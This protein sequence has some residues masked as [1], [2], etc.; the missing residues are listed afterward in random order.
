MTAD[1]YPHPKVDRSVT[2]KRQV[3][4]QVIA[5]WVQPQSS[6]LDLGCGRGVLLEY[7]KVSKDVYGVGVDLSLDKASSCVKRGIPVFQGDIDTVLS[8]F[9]PKSFD[10]VIF[11]RTV[12][13]L[14]RPKETLLRALKVGRSVTVGFIN[15]GFWINRMNMFLHGKRTINDVF[16]RPWYESRPS[17]PFSM[18]EFESFCSSESVKIE[19]RICLGSDWQNTVQVLPNVR[20]GY[21][22][23]DVSRN[24]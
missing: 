9:R 19:R 24:S 4:F 3:D 11:S 14:E 18:S 13:E 5:E 1:N 21:V 20:A 12:E 7:L 16:P 17:N 22:I 15:N 2:S 6:V 23:F 8:R 10:R